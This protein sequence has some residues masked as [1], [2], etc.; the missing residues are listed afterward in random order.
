MFG[1]KN[2]KKD[3]TP[4]TD[5]QKLIRGATTA[6]V[7]IAML[8]T[9]RILMRAPI[10]KSEPADPLAM[11]M[12]EQADT[13]LA[14]HLSPVTYTD[15]KAM[16][17][18]VKQ[19]NPSA[20]LQDLASSISALE[21]MLAGKYSLPFFIN[22]ETIEKE[23]EQARAQYAEIK[24][25]EGSD[26]VWVR[27]VKFTLADTI[28]VCALQTCNLDGE[29]PEIGNFIDMKTYQRLD[30]AEVVAGLTAPAP[31]QEESQG[32]RKEIKTLLRNENNHILQ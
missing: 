5:Q 31:G 30:I 13:M 6:A 32:Q 23:L 4:L 9:P 8:L 22:R 14:R 1:I 2:K 16:N 12:D 17:A 10:Q 19:A 26:S 28:T 7:L 3:E 29:E 18:P 25:R 11:M 27:T 24:E 21:D 15:F 20:E